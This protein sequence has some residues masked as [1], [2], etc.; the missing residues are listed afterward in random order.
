MD[1]KI[2]MNVSIMVVIPMQTVLTL[3][4]V[5]SAHVK[6][7]SAEMVISA[8][9]STNVKF[10]IHAEA[11]DQDVSIPPDHSDVFVNKDTEVTFK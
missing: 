2:L 10:L 8:L 3:P 7:D 11:K 9:T 1:V 6:R 4:V 5:S